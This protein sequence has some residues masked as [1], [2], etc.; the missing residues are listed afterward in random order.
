[1]PSGRGIVVTRMQGRAVGAFWLLTISLWLISPMP[2]AQ[3][4][5]SGVVAGVYRCWSQNVG[6]AGRRC[7]SPPLILHSDG[8]Y[9]ISRERGTYTVMGDQIVLSESRIRGPGKLREGNQIVFE[10]TYQ[11]LPHAVIYLQQEA[12]TTPQADQANPREQAEGDAAIEGH[13]TAG[14]WERRK[15]EAWN[16]PRKPPYGLLEAACRSAG[17]TRIWMK[18]RE[19]RLASHSFRFTSNFSW[20]T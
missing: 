10:Y 3:A 5:E 19:R 14:T 15:G 4:G 1:M 13:P 9:E 12:Q 11:G 17:W 2:S 8:T 7:T 18:A 6:G 16:G 20:N